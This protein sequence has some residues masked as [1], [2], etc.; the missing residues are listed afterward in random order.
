MVTTRALAR[1]AFLSVSL[2]AAATFCLG[3]AN[4]KL[5]L[6]FIDVGQGD[7][8]A[9]ISPLGEIVLIDDGALNNCTKPVEYLSQIGVTKVDYHIASHYHSDHIGCAQEV[10]SAFPLQ[11]DALDRGGSYSSAT[12]TRYLGA[13][14]SHRVTATTSTVIM[15]DAATANPVTISIVALNGNGVST[16]NENDLS[17]VAT[18]RFGHF[19]AVFG[20]DLSGARTG[21]YEDI[22]SSVA[23]FVGRVDVYKVHHHCSAY[24]SNDAWLSTTGPRIGIVSVGDGNSYGHPTAACLER[25]HRHGVKT[26]WTETGNGASPEPGFDVVSGSVTVEVTPEASEYTVTP[27]NG[28]KRTLPTWATTPARAGTPAPTSPPA[29]VTPAPTPT[30]PASVE[31]SS[32]A[33]FPRPSSSSAPAADPIAGTP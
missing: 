31:R 27:L 18:L 15:L 26:Y 11:C 21:N 12:F 20:G 16:T 30:A 9:V 5:Q 33:W 24:S 23:P 1:L 2:L 22:E 3:Q 7:A 19:R 25:L 10:L 14:G 32:T 8:A 17:V 6:H 4:G 28:V 13:I 29:T